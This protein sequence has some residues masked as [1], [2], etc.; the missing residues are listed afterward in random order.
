M[1]GKTYT[2]QLEQDIL[3]RCCQC[4]KELREEE[5]ISILLHVDANLSKKQFKIGRAFTSHASKCPEEKEIRI[6]EE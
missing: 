3:G 5:D 1:S 4:G 2:I 6:L